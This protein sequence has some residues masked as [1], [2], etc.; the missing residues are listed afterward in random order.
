MHL[1]SFFTL[2]SPLDDNPN[3]RSSTHLK[4][5]L[6]LS[7]HLNV[8]LSQHSQ[9][10]GTDNREKYSPAK[11]FNFHIKTHCFSKIII[12]FLKFTDKYQNFTS[13]LNFVFFKTISKK[14][15]SN[16][17]NKLHAILSLIV[18]ISLKCDKN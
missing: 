6:I 12:S 17:K 9:V 1:H 18:K 5:Q 8:K 13:C 15:M 11:K 2:S 14:I 3:N 10:R 7:L 4:T 16:K